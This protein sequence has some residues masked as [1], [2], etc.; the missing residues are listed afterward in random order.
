MLNRKGYSDFYPRK[1]KEQMV[2]SML[3]F[4]SLLFGLAFLFPSELFA[5]D[6]TYNNYT[7]SW[8]DDNSWV[9]GTSPGT[10]DIDD[11]II[12]G[13]II[14]SEGLSF[15][16][17]G[18]L[19][20]NDTLIIY[21]DLTLSNRST[22]T[23]GP[24]AILIVYGDVFS[25]NLVEVSSGG[26]I[27]VTGT[28]TMDGS[29]NQGSFDND[30]SLYIFNPGDGLK[31]GDGYGDINCDTCVLDSTDLGGSDIE[32]LVFGG[33]FSIEASGPTNLCIGGSV[34]L[35]T[36]D[37][38]SNYQWYIGDVAITGETSYLYT[39]NASG[40]YHVEFS[41]AGSTFSPAAVTVSIG[42]IADPVITTCATDKA[43]SAD[44]SCQSTV[45]DLTGEIAASDNCDAS[46]TITQSPAAGTA[47]GLGTTLVT[48]T[49][50]DDAGNTA[51][52]SANVT[53]V[54]DASPVIS[55]CPADILL[56][57][58]DEY[59]GNTVTWTEPTATD[60][61]GVTMTSTHS[62]GDYFPVDTTTVTYTAE[63]AAGNSSTCSFDVIVQAA[64]P[65]VV[66]G[67][68]AVCTPVTATYS[69]DLLAGKTYLWTVTGGTITGTSNASTVD[70]MWT[71]SGAGT[72]EV[73]VT[74]GSGCTI[75]NT[76]NIVKSETPVVGNIE[77]DFSLTRR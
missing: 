25:G 6:S 36:M 28:W 19:A 35:F 24:N 31:D 43:Q 56:T 12:N 38:G 45:P 14:S 10:T 72:V 55:D 63:D 47:I 13:F 23:L 22:L 49:V 4:L 52:C 27:V 64:S 20:V 65:P 59:C 67:S 68:A 26:T 48:I 54:D 75:S 3:V 42:D 5:Q 1:G 37:S 58:N 69:T 70:V 32:D 53:V 34:N 66:T 15:R 8:N 62:P 46:L 73:E 11:V 60:N 9:S 7:G 71:G 39:A 74:S 17:W 61:C 51:T 29:P 30:G 50:E 41:Y 18:D 40:D 76:M 16:N 33:S 44:G 57:A 77:S 2:K 21:G